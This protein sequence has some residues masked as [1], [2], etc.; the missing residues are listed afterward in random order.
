MIQRGSWL[1]VL[2]G[3]QLGR[4]FATEAQ[5]LGYRVM[6][7]DPDPI[8]PASVV[9]DHFL[10]AAMDDDAA[11]REMASRC[12]A[13]TVETENAPVE[14]MRALERQC[15]VWP[16]PDSVEIAQ[17]RIREKSYIA[18]L[19]IA[20]APFAPIESA[21]ALREPQIAALLPG[22][23]KRSRFGYDGKGQFRVSSV[24]QAEAA[25]ASMHGAPCVLERLVSLRLELSVLLARTPQGATAL[26]P[27]AE[28]SH[29]GGILDQSIVPARIPPAQAEAAQA[30]ALRIAEHLDYTGVLCVEFF[31]TT[32][33][34]LLVNEIAPRPHNSGH[35]SLDASY[36]SQF[37]QQARVLAGLPLGSTALRGPAVMQNL[38]G[39][40]WE[41]GEPR[42]ERLLAQ[43]GAKLHLYGKAEA[44]PGRKMG[45]YTCLAADVEQARRMCDRIM[46]ELRP[47]GHAAAGR[48][49]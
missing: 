5:R 39:D 37:E 4:M 26:W 33:G 46:R 30:A 2:G 31:L 24:E 48:A 20:V 1:G 16:S 35:Y 47:A 34:Q 10:C 13:V 28:N 6:V 44:R 21:E 14:A 40:L 49:A 17:D 41:G 25:F 38:L 15:V 3:G 36:T 11:I 8:C 18:G 22:V 12:A 7:L 29:R 32:D 42:W 27:V 45:H 43:E 9:A 19:G 23:L